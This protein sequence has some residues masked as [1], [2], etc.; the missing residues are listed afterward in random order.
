MI[1]W[2]F[3]INVG[4]SGYAALIHVKEHHINEG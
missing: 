2:T 4:L 3:S 1:F